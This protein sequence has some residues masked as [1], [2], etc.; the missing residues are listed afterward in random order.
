MRRRAAIEA[1]AVHALC[2][3]LG[4]SRQRPLSLDVLKALYNLIA[5]DETGYST[6][7]MF[8]AGGVHAL[9]LTLPLS[10]PVVLHR[11]H[12]QYYRSAFPSRVM[13]ALRP[14]P[15]GS[16]FHVCRQYNTWRQGTR[17]DSSMYGLRTS[18]WIREL[19]HAEDATIMFMTDRISG[20]THA[21]QAAVELI[22]GGDS[23]LL[24]G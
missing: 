3:T 12:C 8:A 1:G 6:T 21:D 16:L 15:C 2:N 20:A 7:E 11:V 13:A 17:A 4:S 14:L 18:R 5:P 22:G 23:N 19:L 10:G 24:D 9:V